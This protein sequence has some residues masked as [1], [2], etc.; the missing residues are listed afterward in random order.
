MTQIAQTQIATP[1]AMDLCG[2]FA[3]FPKLGAFSSPASSVNSGT[4]FSINNQTILLWSL[5]A[6]AGYQL[7]TG[8]CGPS[9]AVKMDLNGSA[10]NQKLALNVSNDELAAGFYFG[11]NLVFNL[12]L[13]LKQYE[14]NW[15]WKGWHSHFESSWNTVAS[16]N[17]SFTIDPLKLL[18]DFIMEQLGDVVSF[19]PVTL[20][21]PLTSAWGLYDD[22]KG[23]FAKNKGVMK[24]SPTFNLSIDISDFIEETQ[25][26][27]E[28]LKC[29]L[30]SLAFGPQIGIAMPVTVQMKKVSLDATDYTGL[31]FFNDGTLTGQTTGSA[32]ANPTK[33]TVG[34]DHTPSFDLS[35]GVFVN[36][37]LVK[38]WNIGYSISWPIL[39]LLGINTS[40]ASGSNTLSSNIGSLATQACG[41]CGAEPAGLFDVIFEMPGG[42]AT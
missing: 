20:P 26:L 9:Y 8:A 31:T 29:F 16:T 30:S 40:L 22:Q 15:V 42:L 4:I 19:D 13:N 39:G 24:V 5:T 36:L 11:V 41:A 2:G 1:N 12:S 38:L 25:A 34:L 27:N 3:L 37:N 32:P 21:A 18:F 28:A 33:L 6:N 17:L 14:L 7:I 10:T 23:T 35:L